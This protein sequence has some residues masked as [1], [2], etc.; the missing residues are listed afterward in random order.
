MWDLAS[1]FGGTSFKEKKKVLYILLL[2][3][4]MKHKYICIYEMKVKSQHN[5]EI[6]SKDWE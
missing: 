6:A 3:S 4:E 2:I 5:M 1:F